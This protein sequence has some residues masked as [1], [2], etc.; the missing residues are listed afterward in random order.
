[1]H[2]PAPFLSPHGTTPR[3]H[4]LGYQ[5][6]VAAALVGAPLFDWQSDVL[7]RSMVVDRD[8]GL[9]RPEAA[10]ICPRRNGKTQLIMARVIA[11]CLAEGE[12][13]LYTAHLGD[14]AR[15]MFASFLDL[16]NQSRWLQSQ[17][18]ATYHGK[19]DESVVFANG[20]TFSIRSRTNSGGRGM[21]SSTLILDEALE[22]SPDHVSALTP[23]LA[24]ARARGSGQLWF[25][26]SAGHGRST[27]LAGVRDRGRAAADGSAPDPDLT[28]F[29]WAAPR[30]ADPADPRTWH[31]ANPS[32]G[33]S[34]LSESFLRT[35]QRS[36]DP[37]AFGREHLGWW[38]GLRSDPFLPAGTWE[39]ATRDTRPTPDRR[40]RV[41]FGVE[42]QDYSHAVLVA[43]VDLGNGHAWTETVRRWHD[44]MGLDPAA[45]AEAIA[46]DYR[47]AR[48]TV[49]AGDEFT[50]AALFDHAE[51][52]GL[53]VARMNQPNVRVASH[54]LLTAVTGGRLT[55]PADE[56]MDAEMASAGKAPTGDG[57]TR[58]SRKNSTGQSAGAFATAAAAWAILG[59]QPRR[60]SIV[61]APQ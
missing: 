2:R 29:E 40:A 27:V 4:S 43:A 30:D 9:V 53:K 25:L 10:V 24:K 34:I 61:V 11:G 45:L 57:L 50:C 17:V 38:T 22:L 23:L 52:R 56:A 49:L 14:T 41:A 26:S 33:T 60:P 42:W 15:H 58:L 35:Q 36:M 32:L 13:I 20:S 47:A 1:M 6:D 55:H 51:A 37:E 21:E 44:P 8:R 28:Y 48:P 31:L 46:E 18:S 5:S 54:V 16:L 59:P 7:A 12:H 19:G 39:A 3:R